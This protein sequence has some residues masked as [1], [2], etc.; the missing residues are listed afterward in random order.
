MVLNDSQKSILKPSLSHTI[1]VCK[2]LDPAL[3]DLFMQS[4]DGA[5]REDALRQITMQ[6][7]DQV[8]ID[9]IHDLKH[10]IFD[11]PCPQNRSES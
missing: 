2:Q 1:D 10:N 8:I 5:N 6:N 3:I 4:L 9:V 7:P 11:H